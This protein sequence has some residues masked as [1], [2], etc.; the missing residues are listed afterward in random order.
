[1]NSYSKNIL[2]FDEVPQLAKTDVAYATGN[3]ALD[4]FYVYEQQLDAFA[5][6]LLNKER[7]TWPRKD[8][9]TA[10]RDQYQ[11]LPPIS[12]IAA[13]IESLLDE[14]TFT[15]TTAHQ[16]SLFLGPMYFVYKAITTIQLAR[17]IQ[18]KSGNNRHIVPVF[19]LGSED[20]DLEELNKIN[21]Y[22]KKI[23]W[24]PGLNG[25]VGAM[26][27]STL[28]QPL[29]EL[30]AILGTSE[31][32]AALI[33]RVE[34]AYHR[35]D[36]FAEATQALLHEFLGKYGLVVLNMS[37]PALKRHFIPIMKAEILE[38]PTFKIVNDTIAQLQDLGFKA[39]A[40]PREI[41]L[42]YMGAGFRERIVKENDVYKVLNTDLV[43]SKSAILEELN[44]HPE[45][46]SPN[47]VLRPLFQELVLPNLAYVGGGGELAY[48]L[49][50]RTLFQYFGV[51]FPMLVRRHSVLW[52]DKDAQKKLDK[53]GFTPMAFFADT[54]AL[55]RT[56]I[57]K[58]AAG[59]IQ[60][61]AE[62]AAMHR[63]FDQLAAKANSI[64]ATLEKAVRADEVKAIGTL[65]QWQSRL[66]R[67]EKQKHE[68]TLNQVRNL[69]EKLY[70]AN[71][72][73]ERYDNFLPYVLKYGD[74]FFDT[75]LEHLQP[76][77]PGFVILGE[78]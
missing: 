42:F 33:A 27:T 16:P 58:N 55:I 2:P 72:L 31:A 77:D 9:H 45:R 65:D 47:V 32:A 75:L 3:P 63:L 15:V 5:A 14:N 52:L 23:T 50:R 64:D 66:V 35:T 62:I 44:Q 36:T 43:F 7:S 21:L 26:P 74:T 10:L 69:K 30:K 8:L 37:H 29:E 38:S 67:A 13:Q 56:F 40:A 4:P 49:E 41:N 25:P 19:V 68:V 34:E 1:M 71:G 39:Q 78:L 46:F 54:D 18:S 6:V 60:I 51:Q 61:E 11:N 53:F 17:A 59:E 70:P 22:G 73:Q 57:D 12:D 24:E 48:W 20:H 76:F 28:A